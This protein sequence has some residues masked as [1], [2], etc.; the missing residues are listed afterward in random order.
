MYC[1]LNSKVFKHKKIKNKFK[2][3]KFQK[4]ILTQ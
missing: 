1:E 2:L 4:N 3:K